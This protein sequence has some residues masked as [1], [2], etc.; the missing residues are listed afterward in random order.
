MRCHFARNFGISSDTLIKCDGTAKNIREI[1]LENE[2]NYTDIEE[3]DLIKK[4]SLKKPLHLNLS[5][6]DIIVN[7]LYYSGYTE[8]KS[9][10][11]DNG[12]QQKLSIF[13]PLLVT[14]H[15]YN[16]YSCINTLR[17][18]DELLIFKNNKYSSTKLLSSTTVGLEPT[19]SPFQYNNKNYITE[20]GIILN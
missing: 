9:V 20:S 13:Q 14:T 10:V 12:I 2:I 3:T 6:S 4:I 16:K 5:C 1:L 19:W 15:D 18:S 17:H 8:Y 11:F 7:E